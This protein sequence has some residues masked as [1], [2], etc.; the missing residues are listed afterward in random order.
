MHVRN[1]GY[2][3]QGGARTA[4]AAPERHGSTQTP[5]RRANARAA[6]VRHGGMRAHQR[7]DCAPAAPVRPCSTHPSRILYQ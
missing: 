1:S 7:R 2:V 5:R 6:R 4:K 3:C